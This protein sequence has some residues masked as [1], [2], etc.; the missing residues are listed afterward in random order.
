MVEYAFPSMYT[1]VYLLICY[2]LHLYLYRLHLY[3]LICYRLHLYLYRLHLYLLICYRLH[4]STQVNLIY[5]LLK[6]VYLHIYRLLM[7]QGE[8]PTFQEGVAHAQ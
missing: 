1:L 8:D 6:Q 5:L 2:R 7:S 4:L 3:L